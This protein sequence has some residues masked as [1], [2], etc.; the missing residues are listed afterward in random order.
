MRTIKIFVTLCCASIA[1]LF[2]TSCESS[3]GHDLSKSNPATENTITIQ[4]MQFQPSTI[5]VVPGSEITWINMD[6]TAHTIVSDN[7]TS[8]NSGS[9]SP[10]GSYNYIAN[11]N[12]S[13]TYHCSIHPQMKGTIQVV[14]R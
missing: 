1:M 3:Q 11:Q 8:F 13:I 7:G 5:T 14:T 10:K 6:T 12:G 9:I 4:A 2:V